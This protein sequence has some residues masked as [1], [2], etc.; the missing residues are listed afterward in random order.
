MSG[1]ED[2]ISSTL[3][4]YLTEQFFHTYQRKPSASEIRSWERSIP[5]VANALKGTV[6]YST[7]AETRAKLRELVEGEAPAP[8]VRAGHG[9]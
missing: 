6:L 4:V 7:D 5:Q 9:A 2:R 3:A 8:A 1:P